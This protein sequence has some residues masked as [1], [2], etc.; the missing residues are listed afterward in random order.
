MDESDVDVIVLGAGLAGLSA[1]VVSAEAGARTVVVERAPSIG[2]SALISGGYVW[3]LPDEHALRTED[4][5]RYQRHGMIVV[6]G[7]R[8]AIDWLESFAPMLT[9]EAPNLAGRGIKFEMTMV[10]AHLLRML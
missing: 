4:P 1:A 5:G 2:G 3:A 6:D 9:G 10:F 8:E 7:Y